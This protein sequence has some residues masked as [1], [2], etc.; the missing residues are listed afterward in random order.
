MMK[1]GKDHVRAGEGSLWC[2][3]CCFKMNRCG[4]DTGVG[5]G[6]N[7]EMPELIR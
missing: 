5:G 4:R 3:W 6:E 1:A 7:V 2:W